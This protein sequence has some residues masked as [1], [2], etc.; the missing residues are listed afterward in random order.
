M[1]LWIF[2]VATLALPAGYVFSSA[3]TPFFD[4][5]GYSYLDGPPFTVG[6]QVTVPM[7]LDGIQSSPVFP[8]DL[9]GKEYTVLL[10]GLMITEVDAVGPVRIATYGSGWIRLFEDNAKDCQWREDPPNE[11]VPGSFANGTVA[12]FGELTECVLVFS[13]LTG[14]GTL[15]GH[16][17]F[18]GGDRLAEIGMRN[19][20]SLF[21]GAATAPPWNVPGGYEMAWD[22]QLLAPE[23]L[24][25][26][27]ATWG[28]IK[29]LYR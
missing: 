19:G 8:L 15:Q 17:D 1:K 13:A 26:R 12:L 14:T 11:M 27:R 2:L 18:T 25:A 20:W 29:D 16:V 6:T 9:A 22:A 24:A 10:E 28:R 7:R 3:A 23:A 5:Y 21:G 4:F